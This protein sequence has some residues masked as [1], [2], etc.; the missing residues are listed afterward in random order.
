MVAPLIQICWQF[1]IIEQK[2]VTKLA[3]SPLEIPD[4]AAGLHF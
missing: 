3:Q 1:G 4:C 2:S